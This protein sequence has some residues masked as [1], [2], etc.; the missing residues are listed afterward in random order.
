MR[1]QGATNPDMFI[2]A[3]ESRGLTQN[4][5]KDMMDVT[6]GI[7]SKVE[8]GFLRPSDDLI[9]SFSECLHYPRDF[10][11]RIGY[12]LPPAAPFHRKRQALSRKLQSKI[13][14][15]SNIRNLHILDL[16]DQIELTSS[17]LTVDPDDYKRNGPIEAAKAVRQFWQLPRGPINNL[18]SVVENAGIIIIYADVGTS[19]ID[20][21]TFITEM[22]HPV[23]YI[24]K[25]MQTDRIRLTIAHE[26]GHIVMHKAPRPDMEEE[27]YMFAGEFLAPSDEI[28][29]YLDNISLDMLARLKPY[30]KISMGAIIMRAK[31]LRKLNPDEERRLWAKMNYHGYKQCEPAQLDLPPEYPSLLN[32]VIHYY[33]TDL[34]Y[35]VK[36]LCQLLTI[37]EDDFQ[38][39][40]SPQI[41][42]LRLVK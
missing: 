9:Q 39:W 5:L 35:S 33:L 12:R 16:L 11:F 26:L 31:H 22:Q 7:I 13:E 42:G 15:I 1:A 17:V 29:P 4:D 14:A 38:D 10:F 32:D 21:F 19:L 20:G 37:Q 36:E 2:L 6:Q 40:Y 30:W 41:G 25:N 24:N 18:V 34:G 28:G 3:R 27:A 8:Q 23:I